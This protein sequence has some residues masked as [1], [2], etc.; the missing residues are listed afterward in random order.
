MRRRAKESH[1]TALADLL[2]AVY[3]VR[4]HADGL[5]LFASWRRVVP[6]RIFNNARPV[7]FDKGVLTVH[8][9]TSAWASELEF[10][11]ESILGSLRARA[12]KTSVRTIRFRV[13]PLPPTLRP[14]PTT[15]TVP[16]VPVSALPEDIARSLTR[17]KDDSL[18][19][20]I[21][22]AAYA[23]M[24]APDPAILPTRRSKPP[25]RPGR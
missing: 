3:P 11:R 7:R 23:T 25:G 21:A 5:Q 22:Q 1:P 2:P 19:D 9:S 20:A 12:P 13:G 16:H 4:E 8:V 24:S 17:I 18:R 15:R 10:M 6:P 14:E